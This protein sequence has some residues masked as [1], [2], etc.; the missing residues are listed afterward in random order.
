[1]RRRR[2]PAPEARAAAPARHPRHRPARAAHLAQPALRGRQE[3]VAREPQAPATLQLPAA[4]ALRRVAPPAPRRA[5]AVAVLRHRVAPAAALRHRAA[6]AAALRHRAARPSKRKPAPQP[7]A[8]AR[9]D[10]IGETLKNTALASDL[11]LQ[12]SLSQGPSNSIA[13]RA[14]A[15]AWQA[16]EDRIRAN[17][18]LPVHPYRRASR[19]I[20]FVIALPVTH[21]ATQPTAPQ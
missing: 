4:P 5:A 10:V 14:A 13:A 1:M 21:S 9:A 19:S 6:P 18:P 12:P 3:P 20:A 17:S 8:V 11:L 2:R 16:T 7:A 15:F